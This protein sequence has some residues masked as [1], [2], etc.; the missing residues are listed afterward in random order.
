MFGWMGFRQ[1]AVPFQRSPRLAGETKYSWVK[2][3]RLA[4]DAIIGFSD[5]PLRL[6]LWLGVIVS[7]GALLYG[8]IIIVLALTSTTIVPGWASTVLVLSFLSGLNL[9]VTGVTGAYVGHIHTEVKNRPL[10]VVAR[11]VG[12]AQQPALSRPRVGAVAATALAS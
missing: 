7:A 11:A 4:F 8:A 2:M 12:F 3:I 1:A 9:M 10:Y 6:A 5:V